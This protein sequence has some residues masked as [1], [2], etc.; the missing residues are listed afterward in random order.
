[1]STATK[2]Q[3][4]YQITI[5]ARI[6]KKAHLRVGDLVDFEVT[7]EGILIKPQET[8][9]RT[10]AWFWSKEWQEEEKKVQEDFRKGK[11][12]TN[13]NIDEFIKELDKK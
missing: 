6:R 13:R 12:K 8:I 11:I 4:N 2:I 5:P 9:D 7:E 1:M 10:Q 3:R